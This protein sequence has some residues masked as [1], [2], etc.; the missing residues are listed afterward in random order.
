[1]DA[2][3]LT[4]DQ[5]TLFYWTLSNSSTSDKRKRNDAIREW[6]A[7]VPKRTANSVTTPSLTS[8]ADRSST[9]SVL[10]GNVKIISRSQ[11]S[12]SAKVNPK[13]ASTICLHDIGGLSDNDE[14]R[15]EEREAAFAS[16]IKGKKRVTSEVRKHFYLIQ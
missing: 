5:L 15:G 10:S 8:S 13:P 4:L 11:T 16:P 3:L 14:M 1:M 9:P 6:T 2:S 7:G 12:E